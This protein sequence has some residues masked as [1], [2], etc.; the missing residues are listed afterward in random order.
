MND[1]DND[2]GASKLI[3]DHIQILIQN[4]KK[5]NLH[6]FFHQFRPHCLAGNEQELFKI[7]DS[8][9]NCS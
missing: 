8:Q 4:P 6:E 9:L 1:D 3:A 2:S 5:R 7:Y